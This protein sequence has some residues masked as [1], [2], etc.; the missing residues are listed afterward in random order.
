MLQRSGF[1]FGLVLSLL[2]H[3][4]A[5]SECSRPLGT[6]CL[7]FSS[8]PSAQGWQYVSNT[9]PAPLEE[10]V[11]SVDGTRL[12]LDTRG[13]GTGTAFY[14]IRDSL[15]PLIPFTV[16]MRAR[17]LQSETTMP[18]GVAT[19]FAVDAFTGRERFSFSLNSDAVNVGGK[20]FS[21]DNREF[22]EYRFEV[23]PRS[24]YILF[25]DDSLPLTGAP[26]VYPVSDSML[27]GDNSTFE[28]GLVAIEKFCISRGTPVE[29]LIRPYGSDRIVRRS[30]GKIPVAVLTTEEFNVALIDVASIR[31]GP[32]AAMEIHGGPFQHS[33]LSSEEF[34]VAQK[35]NGTTLSALRQDVEF[36]GKV[37]SHHYTIA[38]YV[39][40]LR[41]LID[42]LNANLVL[43]EKLDSQD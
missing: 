29:L 6:V 9:R 27:L 1:L 5:F 19:A 13:R 38:F 14:S 41:G 32:N 28:N 39:R 25:I 17:V 43:L 15:D 42:I 11:F 20:T 3:S 31:F 12:T 8:L 35:A 23:T 24:G 37:R 30:E 2:V 36:M 26:V 4:D 7:E 16:S 18:G 40:E 22:R 21:F 34:M 33:A 10:E